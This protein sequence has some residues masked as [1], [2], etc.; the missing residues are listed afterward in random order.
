MGERMKKYFIQIIQWALAIVIASLIM[1]FALG[2]Y[3]R[4]AGW[5]N[6]NKGATLSIYNPNSSELQG[7]EGY[8]SVTI[9][10]KGYINNKEIIDSDYVLAVGSS[11]TQGESVSDGERYTD[12]LN[13]KMGYKDKAYVYNVAQDGYY[14]PDILKGIHALIS[15]FP[16]SKKIIMEIDKTSFSEKELKSALK[17]RDYDPAQNGENIRKLLSTKQKI[18]IAVKEYSPLFYNIFLKVRETKVLKGKKDNKSKMNMDKGYESTIND[19]LN[20]VSSMYDGVIIVLYH[21][22]LS[23]KNNEVVLKKEPTYNTF[24]KACENNKIKVINMGKRFKEE[25]KKH[26]KVPYGFSNSSMGTGHFNKDGHK[27]VAEELLDYIK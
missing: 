7:V 9:D 6:R 3:N 14:L 4:T 21:P 27:M 1:N 5:I 12:L 13:K 8:G 20:K 11:F 16:K 24:V 10:N 2:F 26:H 19:V 18:S 23:I 25:F 22:S 15:E 17:Q